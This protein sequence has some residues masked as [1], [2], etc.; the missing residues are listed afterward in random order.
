MLVFKDAEVINPA[1]SNEAVLS[2]NE[3]QAGY[4]KLTSDKRAFYYWAN[5][6]RLKPN[7][8]YDSVV[9]QLVQEFPQLKGENFASLKTDMKNA[10]TLPL[11]SLNEMLSRMSSYH[12]KDIT[13]NNASPSHNSSN[14]DTF[15]DRFKKFGLKN[16]GGE[17]I[18]YGSGNTSPL[19][20]LVLLYL[21]INVSDLGHRKTLLNPYY[22]I[23]GISIE[24]YSNGNSFLVE[25]FACSQQ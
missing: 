7:A 13:G 23:T 16:C 12:A 14:G 24:K 10:N 3:S 25:D 11:L 18:S 8:F 17:N 2:W 9:V 21:D 19:F 15:G 20:M 1:M 4:T 5:Y 22:I 6:S